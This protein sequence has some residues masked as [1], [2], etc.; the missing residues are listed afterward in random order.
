M[1][2]RKIFV[3]GDL[4]SD[5]KFKE[6][7]EQIEQKG[8]IPSHRKGDTGIGKTL[9]DE[10]GIEENSVQAADL[11]KVELKATRKNS[12]SKLTLFT[13]APKKRG[14]NSRILR[15]KYGYKTD[16][17]RAL[18]PNVNILHTQ[19]SGQDYNT[20]DDKPFLKLTMQDNKLYLEHAEDG[21]LEDVFWEPEQL[22]KAFEKKYPSKKLYHVKA[23]TQ[24]KD[25]GTE[26]FHYDEA[27]SLEG[28]SAEK[29]L[30]GLK[31]GELGMDIRLGIYASGVRKGK[32][33]DN[34]TAIRVA[35]KKLDECFDEKKKL[36]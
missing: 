12:N 22:K 4:T 33:H 31:S 13:K 7:M 32:P 34:G 3:T 23:E 19:V 5:E 29:M 17:S 27:Y 18:N 24:K 35:P 16:E 6:T 28:F 15:N 10:L 21:I 25:D 2:D 11:G 1:S 26:L 8:F 36:L 14:V 30:D 9:E 20:L